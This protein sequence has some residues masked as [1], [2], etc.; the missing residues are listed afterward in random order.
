MNMFRTAALPQVLALALTVLLASACDGPKPADKAAAGAV[1]DAARSIADAAMAADDKS[2][3]GVGS[4]TLSFDLQPDTHL[5][6]PV[7]FCAGQGTILT[8]AAKEGDTQVDLRMYESPALREGKSL[9]DV[10]EA[11]Y[12][13]TGSDQGRNFDEF[14]QTNSITQ[15]AK[16]IDEVIRDGD[17]TRVRGKMHGLR[18]YSN[19]DGTGTSPADIGERDFT[20]KVTCSPP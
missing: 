9:K 18:S 20:L 6:L 19:G 12:R 15:S 10:T 16:S 8:I 7:T 11:G 4:G 1:G 5:T 2:W 3:T 17:T 13:F 14:W